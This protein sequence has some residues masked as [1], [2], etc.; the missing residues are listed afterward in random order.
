MIY[1][2]RSNFAFINKA[3]CTSALFKIYNLL[4]NLRLG[5]YCCCTFRDK[6]FIIFMTTYIQNILHNLTKELKSSSITFKASNVIHNLFFQRSWNLWRVLC[7]VMN[8]VFYKLRKQLL[9]IKNL[10]YQLVWN[11]VS[12]R[13]SKTRKKHLFSCIFCCSRLKK[14][15]NYSL[16]R[17][18]F[19]LL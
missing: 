8:D 14:R 18:I 10:E 2:L 6:R 12:Y 13:S 4:N 19:S 15:D 11:V 7:V 3:L 1:C 17:Q 5:L 16:W 9:I